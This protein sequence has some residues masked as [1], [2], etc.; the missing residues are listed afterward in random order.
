M[1]EHLYDAGTHHLRHTYISAPTHTT[2]SHPSCQVAAFVREQLYD[3]ATGRL[4]RTYTSGPSAVAGFADDYA[5]VVQGLLDLHAVTGDVAHL[6]V[7]CEVCDCADVRHA[8]WA[9]QGSC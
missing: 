3:A 8:V 7:R 1:R 2:L 5:Y 6:Q 9:Q 4:R